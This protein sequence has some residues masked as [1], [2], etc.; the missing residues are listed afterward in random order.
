M[1][2]VVIN[3]KVKIVMTRM[4]KRVRRNA[5]VVMIMRIRHIVQVVLQVMHHVHNFVIAS[6]VAVIEFATAITYGIVGVVGLM[7]RVRV[8]SVVAVVSELRRVVTIREI[9]AVM[10][11][12]V[13][14]G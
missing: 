14:V 6:C 3:R 2:V 10:R 1:A 5:V 9:V 13:V 11:G 12:R 4:R 7:V 8:T